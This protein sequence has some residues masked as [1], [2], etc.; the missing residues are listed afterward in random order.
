LTAS[1]NQREDPL[2]SKSEAAAATNGALAVEFEAI[3]EQLVRTT[4]N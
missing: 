2:P 1:F 4:A 3:L